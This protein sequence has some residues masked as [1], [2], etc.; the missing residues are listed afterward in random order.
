MPIQTYRLNTVTYGSAPAPYLA[1]R[2]LQQLANDEQERFPRGAAIHK[3][4]SYVDD[5]L[6]G[7]HGIESAIQARDKLIAILASIA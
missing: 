2:C 1:I 7:D 4:H 5:N 3:N 6:G